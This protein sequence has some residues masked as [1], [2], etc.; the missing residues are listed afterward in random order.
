MSQATLRAKKPVAK[1]TSPRIR[2]TK[3]LINNRWV[4]PADGN[5]FETLN[6]ATGKP[7]AKVAEGTAADIDKAVKAARTA[8]ENPS[9]KK[10]SPGDRGRLLYKLADLV[11][12][13]LDELATLESYNSSKTITDSRGDVEGVVKF[14]RYYGG[15]ADK[16]EGRTLAIGSPYMSYTLRQ[17]IGVV[18]QIIPWN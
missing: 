6:P 12:E 18:G 13:N 10:M 1:T 14:F 5:Y 4:E 17:P 9:W 7:I 8:L 2:Q 3:L 16:I 11:E 15:W